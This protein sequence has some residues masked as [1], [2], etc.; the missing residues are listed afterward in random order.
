MLQTA[1]LAAAIVSFGSAVQLHGGEMA[2]AEYSAQSAQMEADMTSRFILES[3]ISTDCVADVP[4]HTAWWSRPHEYAW[5]AQ[6]AGP[7][8]VVLDAACGISHPFKWLLGQTCKETWACDGDWRISS[9][10]HILANIYEDL[11]SEAHEIVLAKKSWENVNLVFASICKLPEFMPK[12]DRIFCIST[13]EHLCDKDR[14]DALS[15]FSKALAPGG[16]IILT[17]DYP[18]VT[19]RSLLA[20][21]AA[22][23]LVSAGPVELALP[24]TG[25]L[26]NPS[27]H[28]YR[29]V[30]KHRDT[31]QHR[32]SV[33]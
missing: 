17:V 8:L 29:C 9:L 28:I 4:L 14:A 31:K 12:F 24:P 20:A 27:W 18:E 30:L 11:G 21:A 2:A 22:A 7:D 15:E 6:F 1:L 19:P 5:A 33:D 32:K 23:R 25:A 3:D 13:L 16:L 10:D 26:H